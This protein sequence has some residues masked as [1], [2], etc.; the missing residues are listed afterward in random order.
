MKNPQKK[1]KSN[2][3]YKNMKRIKYLFKEMK[4][5][6]TVYYKTL[7]REIKKA[8]S[9][10]KDMSCSWIE[11]FNYCYDI[12]ISQMIYRF[13]GIPIKILTAALQKRKSQSYN[14]FGTASNPE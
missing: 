13:V 5:L 14:S 3:T 11:K 10:W 8:T 6:C 9:K 1:L 2:S 7:L 4:D 12:S